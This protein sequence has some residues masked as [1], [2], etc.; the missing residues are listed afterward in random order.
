MGY[1]LRERSIEKSIIKDIKSG[2]VRLVNYQPQNGTRYMV[3][4]TSVSA[5][6]GLALGMGGVGAVFC[7]PLFP[8]R[9]AVMIVSGSF[10][11]FRYVQEKLGVGLADAVVLAELFARLLP[12]CSAM[13][14]EEV[15]KE[16]G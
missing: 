15:A 2:D 10:I 11:H 6:I 7:L 12:D 16:F 9:P 4:M 13:S 3:L 5:E 1:E 8:K 14:S